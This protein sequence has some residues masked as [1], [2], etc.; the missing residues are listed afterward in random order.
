MEREKD[1][2]PPVEVVAPKV[3]V[4]EQTTEDLVSKFMEPKVSKKRKNAS[5]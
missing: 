3:V 2:I 4:K 5:T 1:F